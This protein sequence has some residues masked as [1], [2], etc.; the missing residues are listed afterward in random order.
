[1]PDR[2]YIRR[3]LHSPKQASLAGVQDQDGGGCSVDRIVSTFLIPRNILRPPVDAVWQ[4]VELPPNTV[5]FNCVLTLHR[6]GIYATTK[7][8]CTA[9]NSGV[10]RELSTLLNSIKWR[11]EAVKMC[12]GPVDAPPRPDLQYHDTPSEAALCEDKRQSGAEFCGIRGVVFLSHRN[13]RS[14][15][16]SGRNLVFDIGP[17]PCVSFVRSFSREIY[18]SKGPEDS[19][20]H[21][22]E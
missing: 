17:A 16:E 8:E 3:A 15:F 10:W 6:R 14:C 19:R 2:I 18:F 11:V 12:R 5:V 21:D 9:R 7:R 13:A 20:F 1:M 4:L 22:R